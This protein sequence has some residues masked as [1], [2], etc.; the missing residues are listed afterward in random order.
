[1]A[2]KMGVDLPDVMFVPPLKGVVGGGTENST[3]R[4]CISTSLVLVVSQLRGEELVLL[5]SDHGQLLP[6]LI[7]LPFFP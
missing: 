1:M 6:G 4:C 3:D 2:V 7:Q 5:L